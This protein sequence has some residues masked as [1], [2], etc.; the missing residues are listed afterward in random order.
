MTGADV[1][2]VGSKALLFAAAM[3]R[4]ATAIETAARL[5]ALS[6]VAKRIPTEAIRPPPHLGPDGQPQF[7]SVR[8]PGK[9]QPYTLKSSSE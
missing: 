6:A 5:Q 1:H 4:M 7:R 9:R 8:E 2:L 3:R